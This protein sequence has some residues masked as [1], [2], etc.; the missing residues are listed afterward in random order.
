MNI[1]LKSKFIYKLIPVSQNTIKH[2]GEIKTDRRGETRDTSE[3]NKKNNNYSIMNGVN[4]IRG[5]Y[6]REIKIKI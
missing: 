2:M 5:I 4:K 1:K 6:E 3:N